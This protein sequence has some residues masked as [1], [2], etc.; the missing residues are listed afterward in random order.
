MGE[1]FAIIL[2]HTGLEQ[3]FSLADRLRLSIASSTCEIPE[4][5]A[6]RVTVS[7]GISQFLL[8]DSGVTNVL[9]RA[10]KAMYCAKNQGKNKVIV[11][12]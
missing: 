3:A 8:T 1:E 6:I 12:K 4:R 7:F 5:E 2:P 10:D 11:F 9:G